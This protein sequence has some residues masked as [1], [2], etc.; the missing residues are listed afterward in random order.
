MTPG[1]HEYWQATSTGNLVGKF[2][3]WGSNRVST[4]SSEYDFIQQ[5]R[6]LSPMGEALVAI[7]R[8]GLPIML[9]RFG[10]PPIRAHLI[11]QEVLNYLDRE[12]AR[13][14]ETTPQAMAAAKPRRI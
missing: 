10:Q 6:Y 11:E 4:F 9:D 5:V 1:T 7:V 12:R 14:Q 3:A 8:E 2:E 13:L